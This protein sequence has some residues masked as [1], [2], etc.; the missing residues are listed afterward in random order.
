M[1]WW[2]FYIDLVL[3]LDSVYWLCK[4]ISVFLCLASMLELCRLMIDSNW[5]PPR[6]IIFLFNGAEELFLL[7]FYCL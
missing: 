5:V 7:V 2:D 3:A 6:P 1:C 4:L